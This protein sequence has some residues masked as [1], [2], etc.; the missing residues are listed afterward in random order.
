[1]KKILY[2]SMHDPFIPYNGSGL[3]SSAFL[4]HLSNHFLLDVVYLSGNGYPDDPAIEQQF[5]PQQTLPS[6][7][8][9]H[10]IPFNRYGYFV[11]SK[12]FYATALK[13][14]VEN[15]YDLIVAD[16]GLCPLYVRLLSKRSKLPFVYSSHN[17][18]YKSYLGRA[19]EDFRR[20][21]LFP[22]IL[23]WEK[24]GSKRSELL[25]AIS[26]EDA[27]FLGRWQDQSKIISIPQGFDDTVYNPF[28]QKPDNNPRIVL[29]VANF[30]KAINCEA[31]Q[32]IRD[33]VV[34]HVI[35]RRPGT[36]FRFIGH[37][38]PLQIQHP[39][40]EFL[41]FVNNLAQYLKNADVVISPLMKGWGMPTKIVEALAC[42][43]PIVS[44]SIGARTIPNIFRQLKIRTIP[45][46]SDAICHILQDDH[47]VMREDYETVRKMY[48]WNTHLD[49]LCDRICQIIEKHP[50]LQK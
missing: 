36:I 16:Y 42:G 38:P 11:F 49:D 29:F 27:S 1:M 13:L 23:H 39:S 15:K 24:W 5:Y 7:E 35:S 34:D 44:T 22:W 19:N 28:Y 18:E 6:A 8:N 37:N 20:Y 26:R 30:N 33:H 47:P 45:E 3:R 21:L 32:D 25:V 41:G 12:S 40:F 2:L 43:K 4:H 14:V 9:R 17:I 31:V 48:G 10:R 46:F 50:K